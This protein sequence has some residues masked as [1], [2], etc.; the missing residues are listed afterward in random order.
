M[1]L[2]AA[3]MGSS[4]QI[5]GG[6]WSV[7]TNKSGAAVLQ[8]PISLVANAEADTTV[9]LTVTGTAR[10]ADQLGTTYKDYTLSATSVVIPAGAK[11]PVTA[12]TVTIINNPLYFI[13]KSLNIV[14]SA[15][16]NPT[17]VYPTVAITIN[18]DVNPQ[19]LDITNP[20]NG[21]SACDNTYAD[22]ATANLNAI[23]Q[24][25]SD[26]GGGVAYAPAGT[27]K[28]M[29]TQ[30]LDVNFP[31]DNAQ[32]SLIGASRTT[33][34]F[35]RAVVTPAPSDCIFT[36]TDYPYSSA[37]YAGVVD[38]AIGT[39]VTDSDKSFASTLIGKRVYNVTAAG[40]TLELG[41][42]CSGL[43]TAVE[44]NTFT[45]E[46]TGGTRQTW[47]ADDVY[48]IAVDSVPFHVAHLQINGNGGNQ[49]WASEYAGLFGA[50]G[51]GNYPG[52]GTLC[53]DTLHLIDA[54][55]SN[56]E[57]DGVRIESNINLISY[58]L[59]GERCGRGTLCFTGGRVN[60]RVNG[61]S[62]NGTGTCLQNEA[63][64]ST[65]YGYLPYYNSH[66]AHVAH[67]PRKLFQELL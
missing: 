52:K 31:C 62:T 25:I 50:N 53:L 1:S 23:L 40:T 48:H 39:T 18:D 26:N 10:N 19:T 13:A 14:L 12:V 58:D 24:W 8:L 44:V 30:Y 6:V 22:D 60:A 57:G 65:G 67:A 15:P 46:L 7:S 2:I 51:S 5:A 42:L 63:D 32:V 28:L 38:S 43:I 27:Y 45:A 61:V 66:P 11:V 37:A 33:S 59:Y 17:F 49:S 36:M 54:G 20:G 55:G 34:I 4:P 29:S 21:L 41:G 56:Y 9:T 64:P 35:K 47:E 16:G 3:L